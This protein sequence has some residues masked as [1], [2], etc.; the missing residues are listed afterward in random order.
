MILSNSRF[1]MSLNTLIL[2][3]KLEKKI[4]KNETSFSTAFK[5][6]INN[7][8]FIEKLLSQSFDYRRVLV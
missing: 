8:R 2:F 5:L 6:A 1:T 3:I 4:G 7:F